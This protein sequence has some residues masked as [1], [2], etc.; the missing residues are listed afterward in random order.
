M[1][2]TKEYMKAFQIDT[3]TRDNILSNNLKE[4]SYVEILPIRRILGFR[5]TTKQN[6][7]PKLMSQTVSKLC[8]FADKLSRKVVRNKN[9]ATLRLEWQGWGAHCLRMRSRVL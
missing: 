3:A 8:N 5:E 6:A 9:F 4:T 7:G 2:P 1:A